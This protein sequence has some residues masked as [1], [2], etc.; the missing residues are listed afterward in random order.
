MAWALFSVF[1]QNGITRCYINTI[2]TD[3]LYMFSNIVF[4]LCV[5]VC[6]CWDAG[7]G[8]GGG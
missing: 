1:G 6:V 2:L 3:I 8:R 5:C 4:G 7:V